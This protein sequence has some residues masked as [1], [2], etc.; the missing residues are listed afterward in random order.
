MSANMQL[1]HNYRFVTLCT[2]Q[3]V[4][5]VFIRNYKSSSF[6][7]VQLTYISCKIMSSMQQLNDNKWQLKKLNSSTSCWTSQIGANMQLCQ[8]LSF[9]TLCTL[10]T[11]CNEL[12]FVC[13]YKSTT[14]ELTFPLCNLYA[15]HAKQWV[16]C[17]N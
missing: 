9:I 8:N 7:I 17:N 14:N 4:M 12:V 5:F 15:F 2:L 13:N 1:C 6:P 16:A 3:F 11:I 10:I